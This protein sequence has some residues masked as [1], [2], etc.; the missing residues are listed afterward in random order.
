MNFSTLVKKNFVRHIY[1]LFCHGMLT[2]A[3]SEAD[4]NFHTSRSG[5]C[6]TWARSDNRL[7]WNFSTA[8]G[9]RK[10]TA[11]WVPHLLTIDQK[12]ERVCDTKSCLNLFNRNSSDFLRRLVVID[13]TWIHHYMPESKEQEKQWV[14]PGGTAPK[15]AKT[16]QLARKVMASVFWD[17]S[18]I[19]FIDYLEKG[20]TINSDY[21]TMHYWANCEKKSQE[22]SLICRR[23]NAFFC[24]TMHQLT[25]R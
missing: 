2:S 3:R 15:W 25:N 4:Q 6:Q 20:K 7:P 13:K 16:Q 10:L 14:G 11:K 12:R 23:K 18:G 19:L 22:K 9:M 17:S 24:K 8:V 1:Q 21:F 5:H